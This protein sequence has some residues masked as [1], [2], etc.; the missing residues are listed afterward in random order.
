MEKIT[1]IIVDDEKDARFI[2]N[3]LLNDF[4]EIE[5]VSTEDSADK[6]LVAILKYKPDIVFLDIDM[7]V[8]TGFDLVKELRQYNVSPTIVFVTAFNE[9]AIEAIK[10]SA[11]DYLVKPVDIDDLQETISRYNAEK[12]RIE[13]SDKIEDLLKCLN[14]EKIRFDTREG[15]FYMYPD[16]IL[17]CKADGNYSYVYCNRE[18]SPRLISMNIGNL[19]K[20]LPDNFL[21]IS[22]SLIIN[23]IYLFEINR[24]AR[25]CKLL[26]NS[27]YLTFDISRKY[28]KLMGNI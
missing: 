5:V 9:Y 8:K 13:L 12:N 11:F 3:S 26:T 7:P 16:D 20:L 24:K 22:R 21:R 27:G 18:E 10:H 25:Q 15:I 2:L 1:A 14:K 17:Y 19:T 28:M 6:A 4:T 23:K